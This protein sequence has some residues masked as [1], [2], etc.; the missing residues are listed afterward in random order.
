[1]L[2][3]WAW[4]AA[5]LE[6]SS[7]SSVN[8]AGSTTIWTI[9]LRV[10]DRF[11]ALNDALAS[12]IQFEDQPDGS[13][14]LQDATR[15]Y[16]IRE[17]QDCDFRE[18]LDGRP[19]R[20]RVAGSR[21]R[22]SGIRALALFFP[23]PTVSAVVRL[24][25][26]F[27]DHPW[28]LKTNLTIDA[29][30]WLARGEPFILHG[31]LAGVIPERI[32]FGF[33]LDG[34]PASEQPIPVLNVDNVGS[35]VVRLEPNRL[36]RGFR[37]R[38]QANDAE[39]YWKSVR[40]LTPPQMASLDGRPSPQVHL[41]FPRYTDLP[42]RDLPD[43]GGSIDCIAGTM[44]DPS[45]HGS[46][47]RPGVDRIGGRP[48]ASDRGLGTARVGAAGPA[49]AIGLT[50]AGHAVWGDIPANLDAS[51]T[52]FDLTFRPYADGLYLLRF[53]DA[54]DSAAAERCVYASNPIHHRPLRWTA[55]RE[56]G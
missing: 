56:S 54:S 13:T 16:A 12:T 22:S 5:A 29:P 1:M 44:C 21:R 38:V 15:R 26:P 37:Y 39:T 24:L 28:P 7:A 45:R 20:R 31:T 51:A 18:L 50:S 53:E 43:G 55:G 25:D 14:E 30:D 47:G 4:S 49:G 6:R 35:F 46:A 36:S 23:R 42:A 19:A 2:F 10:E 32:M 8:F 41:D 33:A 9:A 11:P 27:G 17:A 40:V 52:R 3:W 34:M 48:A